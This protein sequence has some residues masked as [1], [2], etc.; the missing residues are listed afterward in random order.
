[1]AMVRVYNDNVIEHVERFKG[2]EIKIPAGEYILMPSDDAILFKSQ[3]RTPHWDKNKRPTLESMKKI[4]VAPD[5]GETRVEAPKEQAATY[6]CMAC[7][8]KA[9]SEAGLKSHIRSKHVDTMLD[10]NA[11]KELIN[12]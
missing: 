12:S 9:A 10:E 11:Q 3:F 6:Q 7:N 4:R 5:E 2:K 1:M 8:F